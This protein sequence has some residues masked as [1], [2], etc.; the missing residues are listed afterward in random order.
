ML[1][2]RYRK[3]HTNTNDILEAVHSTEVSLCSSMGR[4]SRKRTSLAAKER[5]HLRPSSNTAARRA[6]REVD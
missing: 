2:E 6:L 4:R 5:L 3:A 1:A